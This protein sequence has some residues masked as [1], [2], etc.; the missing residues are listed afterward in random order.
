MH[1]FALWRCVA[2]FLGVVECTAHLRVLSKQFHQNLRICAVTTLLCSVVDLEWFVQQVRP[3]LVETLDMHT[4]EACGWGA[5]LVEYDSDEE[6]EQQRNIRLNNNT[7]VRASDLKSRAF[8]VYMFKRTGL[9]RRVL[10]CGLDVWKSLERYTALRVLRLDA[11]DAWLKPDG[12]EAFFKR[13]HLQELVLDMGEWGGFQVSSILPT[14]TTLHTLIIGGCPLSAA[15][16]QTVLSFTSLQCLRL[17]EFSFQKGVR[18]VTLKGLPALREFEFKDDNVQV[19]FLFESMFPHL[20]SLSLASVTMRSEQLR[21]LSSFTPTLVVLRLVAVELDGVNEFE[22]GFPACLDELEIRNQGLDLKLPDAIRVRTLHLANCHLAADVRFGENLTSVVWKSLY[23]SQECLL[24][25]TQSKAQLKNLV[26]CRVALQTKI[27][28]DTIL[29]ALLHQM[30]TLQTLD[31]S[32]C[33]GLRSCHIRQLRQLLPGTII[34]FARRNVRPADPGDVKLV[35]VEPG[36]L[37]RAKKRRLRRKRS[38][39]NKGTA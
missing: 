25:L 21:L 37:T 7:M 38:L 22:V 30:H 9:Q 35:N 36:P 17:L 3:E 20:T 4:G 31:L 15:D 34:K 29:K 16:W 5:E 26:L 32:L 1:T 39:R 27:T 23:I 24:Q 11:Y 13:I 18:F 6:T 8:P 2:S 19:E 10:R 14:L 12:M 33:S 28:L